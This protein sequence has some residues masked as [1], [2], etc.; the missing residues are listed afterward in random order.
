MRKGVAL[1]IPVSRYAPGQESLKNA[2][3]VADG[4]VKMLHELTFVTER[5]RNTSHAAIGGHNAEEGKAPLL[6]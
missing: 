1:A 2:R 6:P 4:K 3:D 5:C